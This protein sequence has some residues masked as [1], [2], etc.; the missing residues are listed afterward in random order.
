[1]RGREVERK[2]ERDGITWMEER[3]WEQERGVGRGKAR[4]EA[5]RIERAC[6][7]LPIHIHIYERTSASS[8]LSTP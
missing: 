6:A 3:E 4:G 2:G 7:T 5:C 1:M 8:C